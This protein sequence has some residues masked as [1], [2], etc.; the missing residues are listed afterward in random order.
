M[1]GSQAR[2]MRFVQMLV[3]RPGFEADSRLSVVTFSPPGCGLL[4]KMRGWKMPS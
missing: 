2:Y 1:P 4:W 3:N